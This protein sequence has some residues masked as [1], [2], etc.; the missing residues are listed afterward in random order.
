MQRYSETTTSYT[1]TNA[2]YSTIVYIISNVLILLRKM[3][4]EPEK[5]YL[6]STGNQRVNLHSG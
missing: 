6:A 1:S 4:K 2:N 5:K 3:E